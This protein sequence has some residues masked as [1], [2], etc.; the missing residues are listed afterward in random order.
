MSEQGLSRKLA[1]IVSADVVGYSRLMAGD[2]EGTLARLKAHREALIDPK[3][4][5]HNGRI[6]KL[7]GDGM[8]VEFASVVDAVRACVEIQRGMTE[9]NA[10]V[11]EDR[12]ITLR[13][14]VNLGDVMIEDDDIYGDG[15]NVA[16]RLQEL[17]DPGGICIS[18]S[19]YEQIRDRIDVG[20]EDMGEVEVKNIP[21]PVRVY[22]VLLE[23]E[24]PAMM[25]PAGRRR[26][27]HWAIAGTVA[28][29]LVLV[30]GGVLWW[31]EPWTTDVE[32]ASIERMAF[33]LPEKASLAVLPFDN[34]SGDSGQEFFVDGFTESI[35]TTLARAPQLFVIARNSTFTY[36][37]K[38]VKVQQVAEE[39]GVQYV[40]E[41]SVQRSGETIRISAQLIDALSGKHLWAQRYD[42]SVK[43]VFALQDE[44]TLNILTAL[45][46]ELT[47]GEKAQLTRRQTDSLEAFLQYLKG[48]AQLRRFT[49]EDNERARSFAKRAIELD[50]EFADAW[51]VLAW[52][53]QF[54]A[55]VGWSESRAESYKRAAE[56]AEKALGL[57]DTHPSGY[58]LLSTIY[59][60]R[61]K[62]RRGARGGPEG[63]R[64]C[65]QRWHDPRD[66]GG[67][68]LLCRRLRGDGRLDP[69]GDARPSP[70]SRLVP[71]PDRRGLP[72]AWPV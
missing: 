13:V 62:V 68:D 65:P 25:P 46:V 5:E 12:Q 40:L 61:A 45:D 70:F 23:G 14:G 57:D 32:P 66:R 30:A 18:N 20:L 24:A 60:Y 21:R 48:R 59:L 19:A 56:I 7:M 50:P 37:G 43:D 4:A 63:H 15:V 2:E 54:A 6:V 34:L 58:A 31:L 69:E 36:K 67:H 42:R 35:I 11:P 28:V 49:R 71:V 3:I 39:L 44:I 41:G 26:L 72:H 33:P 8:L 47:E 51:V 38:P 22:R 53:H 17:A 55:R 29:I 52:T 16:A 1:A 64:P 27:D 9:R 10:E